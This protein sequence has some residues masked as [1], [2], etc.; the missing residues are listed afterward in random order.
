MSNFTTTAQKTVAKIS[1]EWQEK[2]KLIRE[3]EGTVVR[4]AKLE[5]DNTQLNRNVDALRGELSVKQKQICVINMA[6]SA[7]DVI[8]KKEKKKKKKKKQEEEEEKKKKKKGEEAR[9]GDEDEND[10]SDNDNDSTPSNVDPNENE[11][12][13]VAGLTP[14]IFEA[15]KQFPKTRHLQRESLVVLTHLIQDLEQVEHITAASFPSIGLIMRSMRLHRT[16]SILQTSGARLLW[17]VCSL[18]EDCKMTVKEMGGVAM[19]VDR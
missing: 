13:K 1:R 16:D 11:N 6:A 9:G 18:R 8:A 4:N 19:V 14:L 17:K 3:A 5:I 2:Q 10:N 15:M 7:S 12:E